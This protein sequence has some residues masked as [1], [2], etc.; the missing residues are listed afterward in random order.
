MSHVIVTRYAADKAGVPLTDEQSALVRDWMEFC[1]DTRYRR[2]AMIVDHEST[3]ELSRWTT[4]RRARPFVVK[5]ADTLNIAGASA[6]L[7]GALKIAQ[8]WADARAN[9]AARQA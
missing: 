1:R 6:T 2:V 8:R 4:A 3:R 5:F 9:V 7:A